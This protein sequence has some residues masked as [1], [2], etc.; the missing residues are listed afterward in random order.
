MTWWTWRDVHGTVVERLEGRLL[1]VSASGCRVETDTSLE[2]GSVG[3]IEIRDLPTPIAEAA[4]VCRTTERPGASAR[5]VLQ[6][7]F[8]PLPLE[9]RAPARVAVC[10]G[11][12]TSA[13]QVLPGHGERSG[14]SPTSDATHGGMV[15][16]DLAAQ[17]A[18]SPESHPEAPM[19]GTAEPLAEALNYERPVHR[20]R[21]GRDHR[22]Q[23]EPS[24]FSGT[25]W[26]R[27]DDL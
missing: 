11:E 20:G 16:V 13:D 27:A 26:I 1:D 18:D 22:C 23:R 10:N 25:S 17:R 9:R 21:M 3:V 2:V 7:E 8:L 14:S 5:Y 12:Y 4:R 15:T 19:A 24:A 6:L